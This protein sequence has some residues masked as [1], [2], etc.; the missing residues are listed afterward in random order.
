MAIYLPGGMDASRGFDTEG[1]Y[2]L[3][4]LNDFGSFVGWLGV[5]VAA[6]GIAWMALRERTVSRW[7]GTVSLV[8]VLARPSW[9]VR[10]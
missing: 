8:P 3:Y 9:V 6:G 4:V 2:V 10:S 1:L 7:I 5:S